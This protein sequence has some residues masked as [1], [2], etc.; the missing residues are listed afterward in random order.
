M[1]SEQKTYDVRSA[2]LRALME[3]VHDD[4]YPSA[5]M[6]DMIESLLE[7]REVPIYVEELL[8]RVRAD[9][10]PSIDM[11]QRIDRLV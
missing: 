4:P 1:P 8:D 7:P 5:T 10:F 11:L 6:L 9:R 2:L 3:K